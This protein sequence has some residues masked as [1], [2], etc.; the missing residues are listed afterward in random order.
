[1]IGTG[2]HGAPRVA[3]ETERRKCGRFDYFFPDAESP[4]YT[5]DTPAHLTALQKA[6]YDHGDPDDL[7]NS[8]LPPVFTYLG[9]FID[10][11]I[12]NQ[13]LVDEDARRIVD[14]FKPDGNFDPSHRDAVTQAIFNVRTGR[15]DLDSLYGPKVPTGNPALDKLI[16]LMRFP[17]DRAKMWLGVPAGAEG[18]FPGGLPEDPAADLLRL[19][20]LMAPP[21][22]APL[23]TPA[24][25]DALP[26]EVKKAFS[27][28]QEPNLAAA[29]I[30]DPRNDENLFV[31]QLHMAFLR[32]HNTMVDALRADGVTGT[33]D[34]IFAR[35]RRQVTLHYQ[36]LVMNVYLPAICDPVAL[37]QVTGGG[38]QLYKDFLAACHYVPGKPFPMP[39][40]FVVAAFRFGHS[41]VRG[42]YDW[43]DAFTRTEFKNLFD[44]TGNG[45]QLPKSE[46]A[47]PARWVIDWRRT[48]MPNSE[49]AIRSTR[50][51]DTNV[52]LPLKTM[53]NEPAK[54]DENN[55]A[56]RNLK[57]GVRMN[58]PGAQPSIDA[59]NAAYGFD[60]RP[61]TQTELT[62]GR[63]GDALQ[64]ADYTANTPIWFYVLKEAETRQAGQRLGAFGTHIVAGT[65]AGLIL[66]DPQSYWNTEGSHEGRWHP[67]DGVRASGQLVDS[68]PNLFRAALLLE[69]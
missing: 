66:H 35:A 15:F 61:L 41:M 27:K 43:N 60:L 3:T 32:Y 1:M 40:E 23:F 38:A 64:K 36:W 11:D 51:I 7:N 54:F 18:G 55:L 52:A 50:R 67:V 19:H 46:S 37:Q 68:L 9:Q 31:A 30:G 57:R 25:F 45:S 6:I 33:E 39:I 4:L 17:E 14:I 13:G 44:F 56:A 16:G 8:A 5:D 20:R 24:D 34:E 59:L 21:T 58:V 53:L 65:I 62:S 10:H 2:P 26:D 42:A 28:D 69:S 47:L 63:T 48:A 22:G 49:F 12:T 29:V